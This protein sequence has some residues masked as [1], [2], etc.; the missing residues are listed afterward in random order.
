MALTD[1]NAQSGNYDYG[2]AKSRL[3]TAL[4]RNLSDSET[5]DALQRFGGDPNSATNDW[6]DASLKPV[7]DYFSQRGQTPTIDVTPPPLPTETKTGAPTEP[8]TGGP[9][10]APVDP[11]N[12]GPT[13]GPTTATT[14]PVA[15]AP[16]ATDTVPA[17]STTPFN[18]QL[19]DMMISQL[20]ALSTPE[21]AQSSDIAPAISAFNDQSQRDQQTNRD[22]IAERFYASGNGTGLD[23]GGFNTAVQQG[24]EA[25]AAD[26]ANFTGSTVL[27]ASQQKRQQLQQLMATATQAGD[28]QSAQEIQKQLGELDAQ[29]RQQSITN[30]SSQFGQSLGLQKTQLQ[31]QA[32]QFAK[33]LGLQKF[34]L[35]QQNDQ[36]R[37]QLSQQD[38]QY[39][40][41]LAEQYAQLIAQ[42]NRDTLL[43]GLNG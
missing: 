20:G 29:L 9:D 28:T 27:A 6:S 32:D 10:P 23:S 22:A 15:P 21:T 31:N 19:R 26:R 18:Q 13:Q 12:G 3:N 16:A 41:A 42:E 37:A 36:F 4:G 5:Q 30:Q 2:T 35:G 39:Y 1:L 14:G 25:S 40:D 8:K 7:Y 11:T 34:Q 17:G 33:S 43:S 24:L 38:Q